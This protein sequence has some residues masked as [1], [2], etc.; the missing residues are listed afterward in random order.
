MKSI[1]FS[2][3]FV[4]T[5]ASAVAMGADE[6][7]S[8]PAATA[9][10]TTNPSDAAGASKFYGNITAVDKDAKT[11]VIDNVT[12]SIVP[13]S[14]MTKGDDS[15]ATIDDATVGQPARGS[16]TKSA[17]GKLNV[18]KVRFGKKTGGGK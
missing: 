16:Y 10:A 13:E 11:F 8:A 17:D 15:Q 3:L 4:I 14:H 2:M 18:T 6:E 7:K 9:P 5:F 1:V 12:Y